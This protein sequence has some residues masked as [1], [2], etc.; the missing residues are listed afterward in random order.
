VPQVVNAED[1]TPEQAVDLPGYAANKTGNPKL[2][3]ALN[4]L[5]SS[6]Q[7]RLALAPATEMIPGRDAELINGYVRVIIEGLPENAGSITET[8]TRHGARVE[9]IYAGMVQALVPTGSLNA[10]ADVTEIDFIRLPFEIMEF[11]T[12]EGVSLINAPAWQAAG[13][14]GAGV[15]VGI[16]DG[17]FA[18]YQTLQAN[19]ELPASVTTWW[20][21]SKGGE[22][23]SVHGTGCAEIIYDIAPGATFYLANYGTLA[24]KGNAVDWLIAQ[25][26]DVISC[27]M[28]SFLGGPGDGTGTSSD[29]V[30]GAYNA[31][32]TW[33]QAMG[34]H[35]QRHWSGAWSNPNGN[36]YHNWTADDET[37]NIQVNAGD[38]IVLDL[39]W[40]DTW[41]SSGN[42]YDLLLFDN[43]LTL[44]AVS[45]LVQDG[46]DD[47]VEELVY[48][49]TYTGVYHVAI[50]TLGSPASVTFD[51][52]SIYH[53]FQYQTAAGSYTQPAD[54]T[55][56]MA[57][58]AIDYAT[59]TTI[60]SFSSR[61]PTKDSRIIPSI[62]APDGV[63]SQAYGGAFYGTSAA[64][65]HAAGAAVLVK[66]R[67]PAYTPAQIQSY[68]ES[69]T[70]DLGTAGKDSTY[71]A[72]RLL[73]GAP[74]TFLI[75]SFS[76]TRNALSVAADS[77]VVVTFSASVNGTTANA[78]SI[79]VVGSLSGP[80]AGVF[81]GGGTETITFN[82]T[83]DFAIGETVTVM[84][85]SS[86][87]NTAGG[88]LSS[89]ETWQF[90]VGV[91]V[92]NH[93]S[94]EFTNS[95]QS[96][97]DSDSLSVSIGDTDGDGDLDALVS[98]H[99]LVDGVTGAPNKIWLNDGSGNFTDSGQTLGNTLSGKAV[100][101][102]FDGD[103]DLDAF[104][105]AYGE[106]NWP[107]SLNLPPMKWLTL[108]HDAG[109]NRGSRGK[110][111]PV[112]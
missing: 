34:N 59:P 15:K 7:Q 101:A 14:N 85:A 29:I 9:M 80:I 48:T 82:P 22:G 81:S 109:T 18:N 75:S 6:Q 46:N 74:D 49:A 3:T 32:V 50:G 94:R 100:L 63:T 107:A 20:A 12:G 64:T 65:P 1:G 25:G 99:A 91:A 40:N 87:Q 93:G 90:V 13:Y 39:K 84:L 92:G 58:G 76:P 26:V 51:L 110:A 23:T 37:N 97:G 28:G 55:G 53:D 54:A 60:E 17:G 57:V 86:L 96:L 44:K 104:I 95:S 89:P 61:G 21:P 35:A 36:A 52:Y 43:T 98:N 77:N 33:A 88:M 111:H 68:L 69:N 8:A 105:P 4:Q 56:A 19:G 106:P 79:K 71:G 31:G 41:G 16:L 83:S 10:L 2:D 112:R 66:D 24:E 73:L 70:V 38:T 45:Q 103:S 108:H 30:N 11:A 78:T 62:S 27:S 42:D 102:D 47:P 72:G 67:F 5:S